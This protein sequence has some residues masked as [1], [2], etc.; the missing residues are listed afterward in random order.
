ME[1]LMDYGWAILAFMIVIG[2][3]GSYFYFEGQPELEIY[4]EEC[5]RGETI[6]GGFNINN[7]YA[8]TVLNLTEYNL[9]TLINGEE[10][11]TCNE[12]ICEVSRMINPLICENRKVD[13]IEECEGNYLCKD[14]PEC[15]LGYY[16]E[17]ETIKTTLEWIDKRCD[18]VLCDTNKENC[19][20]DEQYCQ[21]SNSYMC[22]DYLVEVIR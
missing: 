21:V 9:H 15:C 12:H 14:N 4:K 3:L 2:A 10:N 20:R 6:D 5:Y 1:F 17:N 18:C 22:G 8:S 11:I 16:L 7:Y 19:H 13:K